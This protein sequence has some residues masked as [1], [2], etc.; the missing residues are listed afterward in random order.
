MKRRRNTTGRGRNRGRKGNT[1][2]EFPVGFIDLLPDAIERIVDSAGAW[3]SDE[4]AMAADLAWVEVGRTFGRRWAATAPEEEVAR[5]R[6][7][8][9]ACG[10]E[11]PDWSCPCR[12]PLYPAERFFLVVRPEGPLKAGFDWW[13]EAVGDLVAVG[14][15]V[16]GDEAVVTGFALGACETRPGQVSQA[17]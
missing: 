12:S 4:G 7:F 11:W 3:V 16:A 10:G 14:R 13:V 2:A 17:R 9:A 6:E 1:N 15:L 8:L 5:V